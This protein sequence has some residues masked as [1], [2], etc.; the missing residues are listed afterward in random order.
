MSYP[1]VLQRNTTVRFPESAR[2]DAVQLLKAADKAGSVVVADIHADL[3]HRNAG[4]GQE[5]LG[6]LHAQGGHRIEDILSGMFLIKSGQIRAGHVEMIGQHLQR[7]ITVKAFGSNE[8]FDIIE[9]DPV[10]GVV[11][12][13]NMFTDIVGQLVD[14]ADNVTDALK[15]R[16]R[17]DIWNFVLRFILFKTLRNRLGYNIDDVLADAFCL[18]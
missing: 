2:R 15:L 9:Q 7:K 11:G 6:A 8:G 5:N 4:R 1:P 17:E 10:I 14:Q 12:R 13:I 16:D 3:L 18:E